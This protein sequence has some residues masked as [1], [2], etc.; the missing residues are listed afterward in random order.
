MTRIT[1]PEYL[2]QRWF[3]QPLKAMED[4]NFIPE[5]NG[6]IIALMAVFPLYER[7]IK[8][9]C[10]QSGFHKDNYD[11]LKQFRARDLGLSDNPTTDADQFWNVFRDGLGHFGMPFEDS[12]KARENDWEL[13]KIYLGGEC[14]HLPKFIVNEKNE[15]V[16]TLNPWGFVQFVLDKYRADPNLLAQNPDSPLLP[17]L[18]VGREEIG[19]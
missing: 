3:D 13:P 2:R 4:P 17:L 15:R 1:D 14:G 12:T 8:H 6:A 5:G 10:I 7:Y 9:Q 18:L 16:V 11:A 19:Q